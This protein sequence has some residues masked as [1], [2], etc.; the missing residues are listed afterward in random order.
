MS[1]KGLFA[2]PSFAV[3]HTVTSA[4]IPVHSHSEYVVSHY[5]FGLR[6]AASETIFWWSFSKGTPPCSTR[7]TC[8]QDYESHA[9]RDYLMVSI[10]KDFFQEITESLG[11]S[12]EMPLFFSPKLG[13]DA[14]VKRIFEALFAEVDGQGFGRE[15]LLRSLVSEL[16]VH[17]FRRFTPSAIQLERYELEHSRA[18]YQVR[19]AIE[20]LGDNFSKPFNLDQLAAASGLSK[21]HLERVFKQ[22][23]GL[24]PHNYALM[25][26]VE[27]AKG[28]LAST[29]EPIAE[30]A[31][32]LRFAHQSHFTNVF[33]RLTGMTPRG[34]RLASK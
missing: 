23:T 19:R 11:R 2:D 8:T 28:L 16:A 4:A 14:S 33:K 6:N 20:H 31:A 26:R 30:I 34:Y 5:L 27:R 12:R 3:V 7:E 15:V 25:L 22:A 13:C 9:T 1:C 18:R 17:L 32:D 29:A 21:Y 24:T 10:K